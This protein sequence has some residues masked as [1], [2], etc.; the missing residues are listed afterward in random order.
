MVIAIN[1]FIFFLKM[2]PDITDK[3]NE[4]QKE[5]IKNYPIRQQYLINLILKNDGHIKQNVLTKS[6]EFP[7]SSLCRNLQ[8]L[9]R[10]KIIDRKDLG[11]V[12]SISISEWFLRL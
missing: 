3:L 11:L 4:R 12:K 5:V 6:V 2:E 9:E 7:K 8:S 10:K 1:F